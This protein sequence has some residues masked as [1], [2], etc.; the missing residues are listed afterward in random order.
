MPEQALI[1]TSPTSSDEVLRLLIPGSLCDARLFAPLC[2]H[3]PKARQVQCASCHD[4][5][6]REL[7]ASKGNV[8]SL[9]VFDDQPPG[10]L[11]KF[12][13]AA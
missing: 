1:N 6:M 11:A 5:H 9:W 7:D 12:T 13:I 2:S 4:P 3:W 10:A 8:A